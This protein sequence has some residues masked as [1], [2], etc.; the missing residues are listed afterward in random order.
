MPESQE[1]NNSKIGNCRRA[2]ILVVDDEATNIKLLRAVLASAGYKDIHST[3]E[4][5]N[6]CQ[7]QREFNFHLVILDLNMPKVNGFQV[8]ESLKREF[9]KNMPCVLVLTAQHQPEYRID[10]LQLGANDYVTKPFDQLE[11]LARVNNLVR[12]KLAE[13]ELILQ[14]ARLD[15]QVLVKTNELRNA[16]RKIY[17]SRLQVVRKLGRAAEF[18]DN[19]TGDHILRMS[20]ISA[21]I[22]QKIG[23]KENE[24]QLLLNAS[25]M[26]DIG[27]IGIPDHILLKS[28]KLTPDEWQVMKTH[29]TIGAAILASDDCDLLSMA[30]VIAISHHEK[31]D[32]SGYPHGVKGQNIPL[33][34]RITALADVFDALTSE[35]PYKKAWSLDKALVYIQEHSGTQFDPEL[36]DVFFESI[37]EVVVIKDSYAEDS[38]SNFN[39]QYHKLC[40][41][42]LL[43]QIIR[44]RQSV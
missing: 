11:I 9:P 40:E 18:R 13:E 5:E 21:L 20:Q 34:G 23:M 26:H 24:Y 17:E 35:R 7:L 12:L 1:K 6:V 14:N 30:Q 44:K 22:G 38:K 28:S 8:F 33:V 15:E 2:R 37:E 19:E 32:G 36:V 25:P 4:P 29:T 10:A 3:Q 39:Q 27:K 41:S 31:Y 43:E 42:G 16:H